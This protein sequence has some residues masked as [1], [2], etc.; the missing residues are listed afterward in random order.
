MCKLQYCINSK[1][2]NIMSKSQQIK[3]Y[4]IFIVFLLFIIND[5]NNCN[6]SSFRPLYS[7]L[8]E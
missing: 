4:F 6:N 3:S 8:Q 5:I 2:T 1:F 7:G